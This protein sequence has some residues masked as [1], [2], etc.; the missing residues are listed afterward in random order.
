[1]TVALACLAI[2]AY[3]AF[4]WVD[5]GA[6]STCGSLVHYKGAGE[7]C[8]R[9]MQGRVIW[10]ATLG[11]AAIVLLWPAWMAGQPRAAETS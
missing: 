8:V 5:Y 1:M 4:D 2:A 10:I 6:D 3:L 7:P 9:T 11:W